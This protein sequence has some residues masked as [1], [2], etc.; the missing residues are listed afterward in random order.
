MLQ[1]A[2][3]RDAKA[4]FRSLIEFTTYSSY[5]FSIQVQDVA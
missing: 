1:E 3:N 5:V 2:T 4:Y